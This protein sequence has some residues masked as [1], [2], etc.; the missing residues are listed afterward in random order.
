MIPVKVEVWR[1]FRDEGGLELYNREQIEEGSDIKLV[2]TDKES[3]KKMAMITIEN[4][5]KKGFN[6][7]YKYKCRMD[8][9]LKE[10]AEPKK[11]NSF[12]I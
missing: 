4:A 6:V 9:D 12:D 3:G 8:K 11:I 7:E 10:I 5:L 1:R 2:Y